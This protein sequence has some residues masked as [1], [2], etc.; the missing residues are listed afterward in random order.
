MRK[1][2]GGRRNR[3]AGGRHEKD[4]VGKKS[5]GELECREEWGLGGEDN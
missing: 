5:G 3:S 4:G 1:R 2:G